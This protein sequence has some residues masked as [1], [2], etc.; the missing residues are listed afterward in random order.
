MQKIEKLKTPDFWN[1][2]FYIKKYNN[3]D[4]FSK[5]NYENKQKLKEYILEKE[6]KFID[7]YFCCYCDR[8]I[9]LVNTHLEH[10]LSR[11][12]FKDKQFNYSNIFVSCTDQKTCGKFKENKNTV[13][14][15]PSKHIFTNYLKYEINGKR[16]EIVPKND[17]SLKDKKISEDTIKI[18]NLNQRRLVEY[19]FNLYITHVKNKVSFDY[20]KI[21]PVLLN[22]LKTL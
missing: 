22:F 11:S 7:Y 16:I 9:S 14:L 21:N 15:N 19:R 5:D 12:F 4:D 3:W 6:Q 18:L 1:E 10:F 13:I 17:L 20:A 2:S 8:F